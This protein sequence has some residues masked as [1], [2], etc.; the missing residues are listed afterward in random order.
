MS[1]CQQ[2]FFSCQVKVGKYFRGIM[3]LVYFLSLTLCEK[4]IYTVLYTYDGKLQMRT[5]VSCFAFLTA[6]AGA[7]GPDTPSTKGW[8]HIIQASP[9][10]G[11]AQYYTQRPLQAA[12][13]AAASQSSSSP[14]S[15][16][17]ADFLLSVPLLCTVRE[18]TQRRGCAWVQCH[19]YS[20]AWCTVYSI[21][22]SLKLPA[23][24]PPRWTGQSEKCGAAP[25]RWAYWKRT[26]SPSRPP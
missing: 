25:Y 4:H 24:F 12:A 13:A 2:N 20:C 14:V 5:G 16:L 1:N 26:P 7:C 21:S 19:V 18:R 11:V 22:L 10:P 15:P 9:S 8:H 6:W 17:T 3:R 23:F